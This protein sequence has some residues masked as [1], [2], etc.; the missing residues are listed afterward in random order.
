MDEQQLLGE[1]EEV[2]ENFNLGTHPYPVLAF[3]QGGTGIFFENAMRYIVAGDKLCIRLS[4]GIVFSEYSISSDGST[5][6]MISCD[7]YPSMSNRI[8]RKRTNHISKV[9]SDKLSNLS[10]PSASFAPLRELF[11]S[12]VPLCGVFFYNTI[13]RPVRKTSLTKGS[14]LY[15]SE[16]GN[17]LG[18]I[19]ISLSYFIFK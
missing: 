11:S 6:I 14:S 8:L 4:T 19:N 7:Q 1:W 3:N 5:L 18:S 10:K 2:D 16:V 12:S 17:A 15:S 9:V 13:S